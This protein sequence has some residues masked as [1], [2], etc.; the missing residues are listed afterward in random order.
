MKHL[1][2]PII[3][4]AATLTTRAANTNVVTLDTKQTAATFEGLGAL[5]G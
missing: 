4:L 5:N 3:G 1:V 2:L